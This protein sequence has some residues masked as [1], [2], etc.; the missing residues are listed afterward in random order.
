[1]SF[2]VTF[3]AVDCVFFQIPSQGVG[4]NLTHAHRRAG[5][6]IDLVPV[7]GFDHLHVH[8]VAKHRGGD[9]DQLEDHV[10]ADAHVR[11]FQNRDLLAGRL[12]GRL[13][14]SVETRG[15]DHHLFAC[16][17]QYGQ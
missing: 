6:R 5:G 1:M 11:R 17:S 16:P 7:V 9:L 4:Q 8:I 12:D 10:D 13:P 3:T 14:G 15:A 2:G